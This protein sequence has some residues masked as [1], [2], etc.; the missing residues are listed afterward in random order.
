MVPQRRP[1][2]TPTVPETTKFKVVL[3]S[4]G[5]NTINAI[6]AMREVTDL[7]LAE[8]R[9]FVHAAPGTIKEGVSKTEAEEIQKRFAAAGAIVE[10]RAMV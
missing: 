1:I 4:V 7:G 3:T 10:L 8:A 5:A 9:D 6:K 2:R